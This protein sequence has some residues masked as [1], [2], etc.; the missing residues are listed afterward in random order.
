VDEAV[1]KGH[2]FINRFRIKDRRLLGEGI[3][4]PAVGSMKGIWGV[5][6]PDASNQ[7][8]HDEWLGALAVTLLGPDEVVIR[9]I[10]VEDQHEKDREKD[11]IYAFLIEYQEIRRSD[12]DFLD[13]MHSFS[14]LSRMLRKPDNEANSYAADMPG[15]DDVDVVSQSDKNSIAK[16]DVDTGA[17][18]GASGEV[19]PVD[20]QPAKMAPSRRKATP[21]DDREN[22]RPKTKSKKAPAP[23]N[24]ETTPP[25]GLRRSE[26]NKRD[27]ENLGG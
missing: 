17:E 26:R 14:T 5:G 25:A 8:E 20:V 13:L 4:A 15:E 1:S 6:D 11:C 9:M 12:Q 3:M 24:A 18:N 7:P 22:E 23:K 2:V 16:E 27:D 19:A 21:R 10:G